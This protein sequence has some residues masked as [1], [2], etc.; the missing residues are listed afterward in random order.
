[1]GSEHRDRLLAAPF[2]HE[3][4]APFGIDLRVKPEPPQAPAV[5]Q[6]ERVAVDAQAC[7]ERQA[8]ASHH[9]IDRCDRERAV[10]ELGAVAFVIDV[11]L[12]IGKRCVRTRKVPITEDSLVE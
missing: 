4:V 1:M 8:V 12:A 2:P 5:A 11:K 3:V 10:R 6:I 7:F 9:A